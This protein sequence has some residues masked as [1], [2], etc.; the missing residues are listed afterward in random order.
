MSD[1][2]EQSVTTTTAPAIPV[3]GSG[4]VRWLTLWTAVGGLAGAAA[5]VYC[6]GAGIEALRLNAAGLPVEE[7]IAVVPKTAMVALAINALV[8]RALIQAVLTGLLLYWLNLRADAAIAPEA[9]LRRGERAVARKQRREARGQRLAVLGE[10]RRLVRRNL[11]RASRAVGVHRAARA[12]VAFLVLAWRRTLGHVRH[13]FW[14]ALALIYTFLLPWT[15]FTIFGTIIALVQVNLL[16]AIGR[17]RRAGLMTMRTEAA[18]LGVIT[19]ISLTTMTLTGEAIRPGPLPR[20]AVLVEGAGKPI[21]G[22]YVSTTNDGV[23]VGIR[24]KLLLI[25]DHRVSTITIYNAPEQKPEK[26]RTLIQRF[27]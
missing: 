8:L 4:S 18:L 22:D 7:A 1:V 5:V 20:A 2:V 21:V 13:K 24:R 16:V 26:A 10:L 3:A 12:L 23:Y 9:I 15:A 14:I 17:R 27:R 6:V 25:P 11:G 19:A